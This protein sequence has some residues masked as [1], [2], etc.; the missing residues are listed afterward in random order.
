MKTI[1]VKEMKANWAQIESQVK[2]GETFEVLNR[3]KV[4]A[5]IV[6]A[7][8]RQVL[9]WPDHLATAHKNTGKKGSDL[10]REQRDGRF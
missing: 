6:P 5:H 8:P 3:G 9:K 4:A 2:A 1:T 10:I 7:K